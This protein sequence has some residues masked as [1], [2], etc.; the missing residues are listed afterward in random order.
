MT[1]IGSNN[2]TAGSKYLVICI[3]K[4]AQVLMTATASDDTAMCSNNMYFTL[5][6]DMASG[7]ISMAIYTVNH[8][9][10]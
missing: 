5:S 4:I 1:A 7:S 8:G 3:N 9:Y 2:M 10:S 6:K